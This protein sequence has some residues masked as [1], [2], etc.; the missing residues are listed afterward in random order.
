MRYFIGRGDDNEPELILISDNVE[1]VI[2]ARG[3][4]MGLKFIEE[5][6]SLANIGAS[7]PQASADFCSSDHCYMKE[8]LSWK[9][10]PDC[11]RKFNR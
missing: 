7:Q 6:V 1:H 3:S 11:G 10:C 5:L 8:S 4:E 2:V 9:Y